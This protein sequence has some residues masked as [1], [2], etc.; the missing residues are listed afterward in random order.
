MKFEVGDEVRQ[1]DKGIYLHAVVGLTGT[2]VSLDEGE[3][4]PVL[5]NFPQI[6]ERVWPFKV[7]ELDLVKREKG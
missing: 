4:C 5:V 3:R 6:D 2:V 1:N 7:E